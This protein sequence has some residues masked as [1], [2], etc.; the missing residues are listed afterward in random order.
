M[1]NDN[2][3]QNSNN[4]QTPPP[5]TPPRVDTLTETIQ[6]RDMNSDKIKKG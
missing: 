1:S 5:P 6:T 3:N 2:T 4:Q